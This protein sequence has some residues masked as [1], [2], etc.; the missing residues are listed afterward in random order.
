MPS[1]LIIHDV[2]IECINQAASAYHVPAQLII[3]V[4]LTEGGRAGT[5]RLNTNGTYDYGPMQINT[6]WLPRVKQYHITRED[7]QYNPC[8]NVSVGA[9][10]LSQR[11]ADSKDLLYG[12]GSYNSY[13]LPQNYR[14]RTKVTGM[15]D[16]LG[17]LLSLPEDQFRQ[18]M[19][20][21]KHRK[22]GVPSCTTH[23]S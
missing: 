10:I 7:L 6:V 2:P 15:H 21:I 14:Y 11:I 8:T 17:L 23:H 3:S 20:E 1:A 22:G 19:A 13:S 5:A 9:W 16:I 12:I 4:L 18:V